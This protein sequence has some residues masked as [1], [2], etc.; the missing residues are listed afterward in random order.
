MKKTI[1]LII[2]GVVTVGCIIYGTVYHI[3]GGFRNLG[4]GS[5]LSLHFDFDTD[6]ETNDEHNL[7]QKLQAFSKIKIDS[8]AILSNNVSK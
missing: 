4:R 7:N 2:L 5:G 3:G 1:F 6:E 8:A